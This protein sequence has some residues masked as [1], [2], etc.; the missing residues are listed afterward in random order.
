MATAVG[1]MGYVCPAGAKR[2][3]ENA[4]A[5]IARQF[6]GQNAS[7]YKKAPAVGKKAA[8]APSVNG[9]PVF[10][11]FNNGNDAGFTIVSGDDELPAILGYTLDG[12]YD[13]ANVAPNFKYWL[14]E[15]QREISW[16]YTRGGKA[17]VIEKDERNVI[18]PMLTTRWNQSTP[19]NNL[20]PVVNG[21]TSVTGCVAT[22]MAQVLNYNKWPDVGKGHV[23]FAEN[24]R[25]YYHFEEHPFDYSQML[26]I[27]AN[28]DYTEAQANAV[29]ELMLACGRAVRMGY[30]P[31]AS[32]AAD[33]NLHRGLIKYLKYNPG[34]GIRLRDYMTLDE[35]ESLIY[36]ELA[37][38]RPVIMCGSSSAGGHCFVADGYAGN[39]YFHF[40]WGWGGYEDG[41]FLLYS[42]NPTAGGI[43]SYEGGYNSRQSA[44]I[45]MTP[46]GVAD[47]EKDCYLVVQTYLQHEYN[48][49]MECSSLQIKDGLVYNPTGNAFDL[50]IGVAFENA[51]NPDDISYVI[52]W[53]Q[54]ETEMSGS[55]DPAHGFRSVEYHEPKLADGK[56]KVYIVYR[57]DLS[58][59]FKK[60]PSADGYPSYVPLTVANGTVNYAT[61]DIGTQETTLVVTGMS[62]FDNN[63]D[64][65]SPS[66]KLTIAN[67]GQDDWFATLRITATKADGTT[68]SIR[69]SQGVTIPAGRS[70][71]IA[72]NTSSIAKAGVYNVELFTRE[73]QETI[74]SSPLQIVVK[75]GS[76]RI[77]GQSFNVTNITPRI[78]DATEDDQMTITIK[79]RK[80]EEFSSPIV[81]NLM[82]ENNGIFMK[83]TSF[84]TGNVTLSASQESDFLLSSTPLKDIE[85]GEYVWHLDTPAGEVVS[86]DIPL[87]IVK[88]AEDEAAQ[89]AYLITDEQ[90]K[91]ARLTAPRNG[92]YAGIIEVPS[93]VNG[94]TLPSTLDG[95]PFATAERVTELTIPAT[96]TAISDGAFYRA[97]NLSKI[98]FKS[99]VPPVLGKMVMPVN[100]NSFDISVPDNSAN[101]YARAEGWDEI[102]FPN[103]EFDIRDGLKVSGPQ[104]AIDAETNEVYAPYYVNRTEMPELVITGN[105]HIEVICNLSDG[106]ISYTQ[107]TDGKYTLPAL[108]DN[109]RGKLIFGKDLSGIEDV[110]DINETADVYDLNG[111][112]LLKNADFDALKQL[113]P[114]LYLW[115]SRKFL[116]K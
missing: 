9:E 38:N 59:P 81:F 46:A 47:T 67:V 36:N 66:G 10:Y 83:V 15:T 116:R 108:G 44:I 33:M 98:T 72:F 95:V 110:I 82:R 76:G 77:L 107:L 114:G 109:N 74:I 91:Q 32:G 70:Q 5:G 97:D 8:Y 14:E 105:D 111:I 24:S 40:N 17:R 92:H 115:G 11:L 69:M 99:T 7:K 84:T 101:L 102:S 28:G 51:N 87:T 63:Y 73:N 65:S 79:N 80:N 39:G 31:S 4:A 3:S 90:G 88:Y 113:P 27:Y 71:D 52:G 93:S 23:Q 55:L 112:L 58:K 60:C 13:P 22:A 106:T 104:T 21:Q 18:E 57:T 25:N 78:L 48:E 37:S 89:L 94:Y 50:Q 100:T 26:D 49:E 20:C 2:I 30:S 53:D 41:Y 19:Y 96:V 86:R 43:G 42:L 61:T 6:T 64:T 1:V 54:P 56:Y 34:T 35:W 68:G 12:E 85:P 45:N 16:Y 103:W 62:G 75:E 29:A